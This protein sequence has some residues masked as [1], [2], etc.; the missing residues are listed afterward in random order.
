MI[1]KK[2]RPKLWDLLGEQ[3]TKKGKKIHVL[4][5][6]GR[7][8]GPEIPNVIATYFEVEDPKHTRKT[9]TYLELIKDLGFKLPKPVKKEE[10]KK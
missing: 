8:V 3:E 10:K 7:I 5:F 1:S 6:R 4:H 2:E 9:T